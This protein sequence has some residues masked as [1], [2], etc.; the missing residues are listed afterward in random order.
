MIR[1]INRRDSCLDRLRCCFPK[2]FEHHGNLTGRSIQEL[3]F[4]DGIAFDGNRFNR[5]AATARLFNYLA[6]SESSDEKMV[7]RG[8]IEPPTRRLR[9]RRQ[10]RPMTADLGKRNQ[11]GV[12]CFRVRPFAADSGPVSR[13]ALPKI[14]PRPLTSAR[15]RPFFP[16]TAS[17][18]AS[19]I[20]NAIQNAE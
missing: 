12:R 3:F 16:L 5:T 19:T 6:P 13:L 15:T 14:C 10:R 9:G 18:S 1:V 4:P 8:G 2:L 11:I 17:R 7:S 20:P